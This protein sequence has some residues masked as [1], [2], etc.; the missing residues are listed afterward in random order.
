MV[1]VIHNGTRPLSYWFNNNNFNGTIKDIIGFSWN[2]Y[3]SFNNEKEAHEQIKKMFKDHTQMVG[4][5]KL[6]IKCFK[7]LEKLKVKVVV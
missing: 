2:I 3:F 6:S 7:V 5:L 1:F 4:D